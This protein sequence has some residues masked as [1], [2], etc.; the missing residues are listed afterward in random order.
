M[1]TPDTPKLDRITPETL[2]HVYASTNYGFLFAPNFHK[3]L[4]NIA[5]TRKQLYHPTIFNLLGPLTNPADEGIEA[6]MIGVKKKELVPVFAEALK[7]HGVKKGIVACGDEDLDEISCAG[8]THCA[9]LVETTLPS[10]DTEVEIKYFQVIPEDFGVPCHALTEVSPGKGPEENAEIMRRILTGE[11]HRDDP[12]LHFVLINTACFLVTSGVCD[13]AKSAF[14]DDQRVITEQGPGGGRW[15]EG[16][17]LAR[18]AIETGRAW[19]MLKKFAQ[20]TILLEP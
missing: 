9:R 19:E 12:I 16:L 1:R 17:R 14:G 7:L 18:Q 20:V 11:A 3:G 10:G 5:S 4:V 8:P 2:P 6:R 13:S 15:K